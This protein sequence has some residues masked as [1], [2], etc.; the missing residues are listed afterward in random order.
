MNKETDQQSAYLK[1]SAYCAASEH[2]CY[3][4]QR[5]MH[6]WQFPAEWQNAFLE[7]LQQEGYINHERYAKAFAHDKFYFQHWGKQKIRFQLSAHGI[8]DNL[9]NKALENVDETDYSESLRKQL[10]QKLKQ[11]DK[12]DKAKAYAQ[13]M[14]FA[15]AKGYEF[16]LC[17]KLVKQLL[18]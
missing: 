9:I 17:N 4:L 8:A 1:A 3:D 10:E 11:T 6:D 12:G 18:G 14:R 13:L 7:R 2:C 16:E 15:T 5:K